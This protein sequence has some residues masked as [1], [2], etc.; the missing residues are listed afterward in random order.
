MIQ[1]VDGII[2]VKKNT[3]VIGTWKFKKQKVT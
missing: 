3:F 1:R 2:Y